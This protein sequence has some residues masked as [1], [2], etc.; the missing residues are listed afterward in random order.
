MMHTDI[1]LIQEPWIRGNA[2]K[3]LGRLPCFNKKEATKTRAW[4]V[5]KGVK[6]IP[7][8]EMTTR[9]IS[10]EMGGVKRLLLH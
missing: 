5:T 7:L 2:I 9:V 1:A 3:G 10:T 6:V 8:P 4:I